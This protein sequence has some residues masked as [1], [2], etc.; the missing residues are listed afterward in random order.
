MENKY[1]DKP[2]LNFNPAEGE[3]TFK[4]SMPKEKDVKRASTGTPYVRVGLVSDCN[5]YVKAVFFGSPKALPRVAEFIG[6]ATGTRPSTASVK[7]ELTLADLL[8]TASGKYVKATVKLGKSRE[9][10]GKTYQDYDV[11]DFKAPF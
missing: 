11:T 7:D 1:S 5:A 8:A 10:N 9:Q 6:A 3:Y 4:V 2:P